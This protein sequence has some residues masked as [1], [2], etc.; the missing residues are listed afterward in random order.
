MDEIG[1][2]Y[3]VR[4]V[5]GR[6]RDQ[7]R[8]Y[9][10]PEIHLCNKEKG[11]GQDRLVVDG[12]H[13]FLIEH[14]L[15]SLSKTPTTTTSTS[16]GTTTST[17]S[18]GGVQILLNKSV[19]QVTIHDPKTTTQNNQSQLSIK[20]ALYWGGD[21][22]NQQRAKSISVCCRDGSKYHCQYV[23]CT[24]PLGV[25][26]GRSEHSSIEWSPLLSSIKRDCIRSLG[27]G[28]HNKVVMRF[29][30]EDVFWPPHTPQLLCPDPRFHFLNLNAYGK[31]GMML[32]HV[33]PPFADSWIN[34]SDKQVTS[35]AIG[36]LKGMFRHKYKQKGNPQ[37]LE[38]VVTRW[39][40]DPFSM[41][42]YSYLKPGSTWDH[43]Q[44]LNLPHP[45][46]GEP[47]VFFAGEALSVKGFQ[48]VDGAYESGVRAGKSV[49]DCYGMLKK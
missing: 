3:H 5:A 18:G 17:S 9:E 45:Q 29:R 48:C 42:S 20:D 4:V 6:M 19:S 1:S 39:N 16:A 12:Y 34:L 43:I 8:K 26:K 15:T 46:V 38:S 40:T 35:Q 11:G 27:M 14:L 7:R 24:V 25:L 28:T 41:G 47:R 21:K 31:T 13:G 44:I 2:D 33:W 10:Q 37:P 23:I 36:V 30:A 22:S 49:L 32:C